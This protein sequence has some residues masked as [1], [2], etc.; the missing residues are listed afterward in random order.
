MKIVLSVLKQ[1]YLHNLGNLET[2]LWSDS[3]SLLT[4]SLIQLNRI[5]ILQ[6]PIWYVFW[7][8]VIA[9][10]C[11]GYWNFLKEKQNQN[12]SFLKTIW[13]WVVYHVWKTWISRAPLAEVFAEK[14]G[15]QTYS[16]VHVWFCLSWKSASAALSTPWLF[17]SRKRYDTAL[18][19]PV[20]R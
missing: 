5:T 9:I 17:Y 19:P 11:V 7:F 14:M 1:C 16:F 15:L 2:V 6:L 12:L 20:L 4:Y 3:F 13:S 18:L 8:W 10:W